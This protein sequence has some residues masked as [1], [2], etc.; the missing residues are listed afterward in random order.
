MAREGGF[1]VRREILRMMLEKIA[2]DKYPSGQ[3]MNFVE[4]MLTPQ[5]VQAYAEV[6]MEKVQNERHPSNDMLKRLM[7]L[8]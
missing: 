2:E 5:Y 6:L 8:A 7:A 4:Q 1:D 3:M